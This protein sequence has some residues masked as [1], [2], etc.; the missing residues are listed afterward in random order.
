MPSSSVTTNTVG[1]CSTGSPVS[2][3]ASRV[4]RPCPTSRRSAGSARWWRATP[5]RPAPVRSPARRPCT[6]LFA[7]SND[8]VPSATASATTGNV[9]IARPTSA[10]AR[11]RPGAYWRCHPAKR[12]MSR[13]SHAEW[14]PR[15]ST[16]A[17]TAARFASAAEISP[18]SSRA[19]SVE[20]VVSH[21]GDLLE[22]RRRH[23]TTLLGDHTGRR[24]GGGEHVFESTDSD[25]P[26]GKQKTLEIIEVSQPWRWTCAGR[27]RT[28]TIGDDGP[29]PGTLIG[30]RHARRHVETGGG[31]VPLR[32]R[33]RERAMASKDRAVWVQRV[34]LVAVAAVLLTLAVV[35]GL[36]AGDRTVTRTGQPLAWRCSPTTRSARWELRRS[37]RCRCRW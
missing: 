15:R 33:G 6:M 27:G 30:N 3:S 9:S 20:L 22:E 2:G 26:D 4:R 25:R 23:S 24:V 35:A 36:W 31:A 8:S 10:S 17:S 11:A 19:R 34:V 32:I 7:L 13:H 16:S 1:R 29:V 5:C 14:I 12:S 21:L 28:P 37:G 18:A